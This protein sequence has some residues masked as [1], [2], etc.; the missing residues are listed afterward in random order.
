M[1]PAVYILASQRN[2]TLYIGVT[3]DLVQ[4]IYQHREHLIEGFTLRYNVTMLVWYELHPTM[5][6]AITREKQ[7]KKWNRAWK[8]QLIE[9]NNVSWQ[10]LWFDII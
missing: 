2:G 8:L 9:E 5:E 3:S 1:Q 4:R 6:S 10:D 7:L